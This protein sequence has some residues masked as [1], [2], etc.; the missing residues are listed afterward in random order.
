MTQAL[1][2]THRKV[3]CSECKNVFRGTIF[4]DWFV[5]PEGET[6][7]GRPQLVYAKCPKC[8]KQNEINE[9]LPIWDP[10]EAK[11]TH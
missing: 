6:L 2:P 11:K 9:K 4:Y 5:T 3:Q 1:K 10:V 7:R 8:G